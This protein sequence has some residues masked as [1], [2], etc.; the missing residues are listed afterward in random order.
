MKMFGR[1]FATP[2]HIQYPRRVGS[3]DDPRVAGRSRAGEILFGKQRIKSSVEQKPGVQLRR[4]P[5]YAGGNYGRR[6]S[7]RMLQRQ[8]LSLF[9]VVAGT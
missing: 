3:C 5:Q 7:G 9:A 4:P 8:P 2:K 6:K 1:G